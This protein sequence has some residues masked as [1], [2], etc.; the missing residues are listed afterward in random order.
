M[1]YTVDK[2]HWLEGVPRD[3]LPD[4][5]AMNN[6]V[7]L[8]MHFTGGWTGSAQVMR[9]R[10]VSAHIIIKRDGTV[11]QCVPFNRIAYHAGSSSWTLNGTRI[12]NLNPCSIGIELENCGDLERDK[13]PQTL[14][15][16]VG[17]PIPRIE[18][19]HKNG[20]PV[21]KWEKYTDAQL[22][23]AAD[24]GR[25]VKARYNLD[26]CLGHDDIAPDRKNDPGP[27]FPMPQFRR[28]IG[29]T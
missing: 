14:P 28:A 23:A 16:L 10:G 1:I 25:A 27:A 17:Q 20:G 18:A 9:D 26:A 15:D 4:G 2:N 11:I 3:P 21:K 29:F 19:R 6:R 22:A 7:F 24:V 13:Y 5:G 12:K 8:I